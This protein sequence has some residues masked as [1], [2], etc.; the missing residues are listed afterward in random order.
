VR[1][2]VL[3]GFHDG[4]FRASFGT[5]L[6]SLEAIVS[7]FRRKDRFEL[8]VVPQELEV[9]V[10]DGNVAG[11]LLKEGLVFVMEAIVSF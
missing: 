7:L 2:P 11:G 4:A 9:T 10:L 6:V 3:K 1:L 5:A 8:P